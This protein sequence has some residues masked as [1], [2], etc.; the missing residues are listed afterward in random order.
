MEY[1]TAIKNEIWPFATTWVDLEGIT[2]SEI[3]Q[4]KKDKYCMISYMES[5]KQNKQT[6]QNKNRFIDNREQMG[7]CQWEG[8]K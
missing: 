1:Y 3:C 8:V 2:L 6:K 5:K 7:G 4:T